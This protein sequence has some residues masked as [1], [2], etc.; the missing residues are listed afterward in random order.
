MLPSGEELCSRS[1]LSL[2]QPHS[3]AGIGGLVLAITIGKYDPS[4]PIDLYEAHDSIDT[5]GVGISVTKKTHQ[6][7]IE[8]GLFDDF[9]QL[10]AHDPERSRGEQHFIPRLCRFQSDRHTRPQRKASRHT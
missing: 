6:V 1:R 5:A 2:K 3:G 4:I 9:K 7:L 10:L 8:L